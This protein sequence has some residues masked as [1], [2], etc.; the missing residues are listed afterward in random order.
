[1]KISELAPAIGFPSVQDFLVNHI[2]MQFADVRAMLQLPRP[3]LGITAGC[4]FAIVSTLCNLI[5]GISTTIFAPAKILEGKSCGSGQAFRQLVTE[6]FPYAPTGAQDF[7]KDL[8]KLCRN[9]MAHAAGITGTAAPRVWF[10]RVLDPSH[11]DLGWSDKELEDIERPDR[12]FS[13][14]PGI[15]VDSGEWKLNCDGFY[16]DVVQMLRRLNSNALQMQAA[17]TRFA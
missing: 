11:A 6:F 17:E 2:D 16:M 10:V 4:N 3:D 15:V 8:Y 9:S 5:S 13:F 1:M 7:S 14:S 12:P